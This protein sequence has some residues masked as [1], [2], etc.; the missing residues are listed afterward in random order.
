MSQDTTSHPPCWPPLT[1]K[2]PPPVLPPWLAALL[3]PGEEAVWMSR[4]SPRLWAWLEWLAERGPL[5]PFALYLCLPV[6]ALGGLTHSSK[7]GLVGALLLGVPPRLG[8]CVF[9]VWVP[10]GTWYVVTIH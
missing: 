6:S 3:Q 5:L 8:A 4:S 7:R 9:M 10:S 1:L 2:L